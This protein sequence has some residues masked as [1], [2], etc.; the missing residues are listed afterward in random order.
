MRSFNKTV[1]LLGQFPLGA[2][3][4]RFIHSSGCLSL[5][6]D[7]TIIASQHTI[8]VKLICSIA[9][10]RARLRAYPA[11]TIGRVRSLSLFCIWFLFKMQ[12]YCYSVKQ[13]LF[14]LSRCRWLV[15]RCSVRMLVCVALPITCAQCTLLTAR[16][17]LFFPRFLLLNFAFR[18]SLF[19]FRC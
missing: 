7:F 5:S 3:L 8:A 2:L 11:S 15:G 1:L 16:C 4:A 6:R 17:I 12:L 18:F 9:H 13:L 14:M 19:A 10:T